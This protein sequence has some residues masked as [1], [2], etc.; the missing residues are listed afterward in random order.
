MKVSRD[1][2]VNV[3]R[4]VENAVGARDDFHFYVD[5][6]TSRNYMPTYAGIADEKYAFESMDEAFFEFLNRKIA[7]D[8]IYLR[9]ILATG[10]DTSNGVLF[11]LECGSEVKTFETCDVENGMVFDFADFGVKIQGG[12]VTLGTTVEGGCAHTPYF[13]PFGSERGNEDYLSLDNPLNRFVIDLL[14]EM[15]VTDEL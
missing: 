5:E 15:I 1:I 6:L 7:G 9:L 14:W 12:R 4:T 10:E 13:A 3:I 8:G 11:T 2:N